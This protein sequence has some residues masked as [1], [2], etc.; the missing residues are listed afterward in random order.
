MSKFTL[1]RQRKNKIEE[2]ISSDVVAIKDHVKENVEPKIQTVIQAKIDTQKK[3]PIWPSIPDIKMVKPIYKLPNL[4][5]KKQLNRIDIKEVEVLPELDGRREES[6]QRDIEKGLKINSTE[7]NDKVT[8]KK[9]V[10]SYSK[11]PQPVQEFVYPRTAV[12]FANTWQGFDN[13][14]LKYE[15]LRQING[16]D[17]S[18]IFKE[19]LDTKL[20]SD[21]LETLTHR[22]IDKSENVYSYLHGLSNVKRFSTLTMF[23]TSKDKESKLIYSLISIKY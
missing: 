19:S 6:K 2:A 1:S 13:A 22:F 5:S 17:I 16:E 11:Q 12:Q 15:Y 4:R 20:F 18:V 23:M 8:E 14:D 7:S 9:Q 3:T 10:A 21:I